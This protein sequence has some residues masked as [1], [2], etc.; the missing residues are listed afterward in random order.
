MKFC[1]HQLDN[2]LDI[3]AEVNEQARSQALAFFVRTGSRDESDN[4]SGVSHFL[5]HMMFKGTAERSAE[6]V[7]RE[8]DAIGSQSNAYTSEEQTVYY[9]AI[10]PE[11]QDRGVD[12]ISDMMRPALRTEDFETEK[13]VIVEEICMYDD[14][15][16]YGAHERCMQAFFG[17]HPL[18]RSVL[19]TV[20]SVTALTPESMR[21]YFD[22]RYSP[23]NMVLVAAGKVDFDRLVEHAKTHCDA[24]QAVETSR[25]APSTLGQS[26]VHLR[27]KESAIQ[28]YAVQLSAAPPVEDESRFAA[29][30]LA[31]IL[32][33]E[34]GS[35][36]YWKLIESGRAEYA[37]MGA[38]EYAGAGVFLTYLGCAP[39]D[40][41]ENLACIREVF[42]EVHQEGITEDELLL[43]KSKIT[44]SIVLGSERPSGRLF[45]VGN[46][47]IQH[48]NHRTVQ[49]AVDFYQAVTPSD[50]ADL[51]AKY[52]LLASTTYLAGPLTEWEGAT[53]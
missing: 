30:I 53:A 31:T 7:N 36:L 29:R 15:P 20:E 46:N 23:G 16:P 19:G 35:R 1:H 40:A 50:I 25:N 44:S 49:E 4:N 17:E 22:L 38:Y 24:W 51:L 43:A 26:G 34:S 37:A 9:T 6:E 39:D 12:L 2:G 14:Q 3:V 13:Q 8:L 32:G 21:A 52:D 42:H 10:L 27:V 18:G 5:E 33:D 41:E 48:G 45:S 47:W 11:Y 28:Q